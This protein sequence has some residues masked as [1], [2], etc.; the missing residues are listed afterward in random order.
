MF[1]VGKRT[2]M[3][4]EQQAPHN[5]TYVALGTGLLWFGWFGF[6]GG[7]A[8]TANGVAAMAFVN[9]DIAGSIAMITWLFISWIHEK[10]PSFV[11]ALTGA[12]AGL[13]M[14]TPAAGY[15]QPWAAVVIGL[16]AGSVCYL[17]IQL[18]MKW[19]WDDAL[20]VWGV[21]GV[22]GVVGSILVGVFAVSSVNGVDGLI[23]GNAHQFW[24]QLL[25]VAIVT[26]Y[27]FVITLV[28]LKVINIFVPV[29][30]PKEVEINGLDDSIHKEHAYEL[31]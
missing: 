23:A 14:V 29:R 20:D 9:T 25:A 11:G 17:A 4:K 19:G 10:R 1:F 24:I 2:M 5:I 3:E 8:L 22:G 13:A 7:S 28:L 18:R 21:H 12:V 30:V 27:T 31:E 26:A 15:I 16:V 6:N